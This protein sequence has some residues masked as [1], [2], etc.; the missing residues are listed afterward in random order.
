[1]LVEEAAANDQAR[2]GT[3][4]SHKVTLAEAFQLRRSA[5]RSTYLLPGYLLLT[6]CL[7]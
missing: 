4:K 6:D 7:C 2:N 1:M 3:R 5:A